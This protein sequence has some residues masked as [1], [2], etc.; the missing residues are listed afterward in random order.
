MATFD[1]KAALRELRGKIA[2]DYDLRFRLS[3]GQKAAIRRAYNAYSAVSKSPIRPLEIPRKRGE[4]M[5]QY[6]R[7]FR[8]TRRELMHGLA[9]DE[10]G[11]MLATASKYFILFTSKPDATLTYSHKMV[12]LRK[13]NY[14]ETYVPFTRDFGTDPSGAIWDALQRGMRSGIKP[15]SIQIANGP[16]RWTGSISLLDW[17]TDTLGDK[18]RLREYFDAL[19]DPVL[20]R[21]ARYTKASEVSNSASGIWLIEY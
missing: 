4:S 10:Q 17:Y 14:T 1:Y 2:F 11:R 13:G 8:K 21:L 18:S 16:F 12:T 15:V 7:R 3:P 5:A 9:A 19:M 6:A 20:G